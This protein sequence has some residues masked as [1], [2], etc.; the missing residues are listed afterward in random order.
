MAIL[1]YQIKLI[2]KFIELCQVLQVSNNE[3]DCREI[4]SNSITSFQYVL[5][6]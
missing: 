5:E 3:V 2:R 4:L 6:E 1:H